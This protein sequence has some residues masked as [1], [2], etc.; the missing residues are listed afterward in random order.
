M[1]IASLLLC[2]FFLTAPAQLAFAE[3]DYK[4]KALISNGRKPKEELLMLKFKE[5]S[6][7]AVKLKKKVAVKEFNYADVISADYSYSK[8][9]VFSPTAVIAAI[10]VVGVLAAPLLFLKKKTHW[11]SVRTADDYLVLRLN[12]KNHRAILDEF[13]SRKIT[14]NY[15]Y[16]DSLDLRN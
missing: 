11:L 15:V 5:T 9:P 6:F 7:S 8:K 13:F 12:G 10:F 2:V 14:V 16:E 1:K 3:T 4:V